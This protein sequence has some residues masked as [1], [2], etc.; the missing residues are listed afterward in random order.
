MAAHDIHFEASATIRAS[1]ATV[2]DLLTDYRNGH[3]RI[4]P[5]GAFSHFTVVEGGKG[6]GTVT[7][8]VFHVAGQR[9]RVRHT[10][11]APEPGRAL[12]EAEPDGSSTTTFTLTPLEGGRQTQVTISTTQR[13]NLGVRGAVEGLIAALIAPSM[14]RIY[15]E[16]LNRLDVLAQT[17]PA[18]AS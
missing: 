16:E 8:F 14:R 6:A 4:L 12:T 17:W 3:P 18:G 15:L 11:S 13:G 1:P 10:V 5:P 9:R 2:W 7:T